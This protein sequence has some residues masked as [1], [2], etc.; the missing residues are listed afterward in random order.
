[1][2]TRKLYLLDIPT[3]TIFFD[4]TFKCITWI[5]ENDGDFRVEYFA[6]LLN[7]YGI[8]VY[9][10]KTTDDFWDYIESK[11]D[12]GSEVHEFEE[13]LVEYVRENSQN[14]K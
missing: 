8:S 13:E 14:G 3:C 11:V 10:V 5:H 9:H 6:P 1:M 7:H 2:G 12:S 4:E